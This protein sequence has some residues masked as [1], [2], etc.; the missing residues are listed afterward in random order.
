VIFVRRYFGMEWPTRQLYHMMINS[1]MG[2]EAVVETIVK[3]IDRVDAQSVFAELKLA[4]Q[5][6]S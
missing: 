5:G 3:V 4:E 2:D 6:R 1:T